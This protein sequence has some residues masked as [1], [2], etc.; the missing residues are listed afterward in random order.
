MSA[1][2][3]I[4]IVDE[5][6]DT[7]EEAA[8]IL[9]HGGHEVAEAA[10]VEDAIRTAHAN[11]PTLIL[12]AASA[13]GL[14]VLRRLRAAP[15]VADIPVVLLCPSDI[16]P[17]DHS[18]CVDLG[19][20]GYINRPV[21]EDELLARVG[22]HLRQ[23]EL[24]ARLRASEARFRDLVTNQADGVLV[25]GREGTIQFANPAA[26]ALFGRSPDALVGQPFGFPIEGAQADIIEIQ[27][28]GGEEIHAEMRVGATEWTGQ[29]AWIATLS[30]VT[31]RFRAEVERSGLLHE[32]GERI[33]ELRLYHGVSEI[34]KHDEAGL[35]QIVSEIV[36]LIPPA[37]QFPECAEAEIVLGGLH[38]ATSGYLESERSLSVGFP[39]CGAQSGH[40]NVAYPRDLPGRG[41]PAFLGEERSILRALGEM[42]R[43]TYDRRW[44]EKEN[45]RS[46]ALLRIAGRVARI[47]GWSID[48]PER[49]LT[50]SEEMIAIH[51]LPPGHQPTLEESVQHYLPGFRAKV[52]EMVEACIAHGTPI[53]IEAE[54]ISAKGRKVWISA[55]GE[56]VRDKTGR[57]VRLQGAMQDISA[58]KEAEAS[59]AESERRFR[60]LAE[61]MPMI[62]W[63]ADSKGNINFANQKLFETTGADPG[64]D[65]H[66]RWHSFVH[67]DDLDQALKEWARCVREETLYDI[68]YRL[69]H[70][71]DEQ[72]HWFRVQGQPI[73]DA[74]GAVSHWFGTGIDIHGIKTL[75]EK[76]TELTKRLT[77]TLESI[78]DGFFTLDRDWRFTYVNPEVERFLDADR[79][80]IIGKILWDEFPDVKGTPIDEAYRKAM[81]KNVTVRLETF[82]APAQRWINLRVYPSADGLS[83]FIQDI[84]QR[85]SDEEQMRLLATAMAS[86]NDIVIITKAAPLEEPGP[87]IVFVNDAFERL[88]GYTAAEALGRTPRMLQGPGSDLEAK[89][90]MRE[91]LAAGQTIREEVINYA[92]DGRPYLLEVN[93]H[94][95]R[96]ADGVVTHFVAVERDIT[97]EQEVKETL[98]ESEERFRTLL[99]DIP[100]VAIQ[101]YG[102]DGAVNYWNKASEALYG[103]T[104]EEAMQGNL[105][106]L[107]IPPEMRDEVRGALKAVEEGLDHLPSAELCLMRKDGSRVDVLSSHAVL[108]RPGH[109]VEFYCIDIDLTER[110][111]LETQFLRAQRMESIGTLAGGI[112]HDLN[113]MLSPVI[114]GASLMRQLDEGKTMHSIID[115]IQRSAER[116]RELVKQV[117]SFARGADGE[118]VILEVGHFVH[119]IESIVKSTFPKNITFESEIPDHLWKIPADPTQ[120]H[121]VLINLCVNARDAMPNGGLLRITAENLTVDRQY[122]SMFTEVRPGRY[123]VVDICDDGCGM[124]AAIRERVFEPFFTTKEFGDGTGLGLSTVM[125]IVRGH[126]G[127]INVYSEP[128]KGSRFRICLPSEENQSPV[129]EEKTGMAERTIPHGNGECILVVDDEAPI[130]T[131]SK[132]ALEAYGYKVI[133]AEDGAEGTGIFAIHQNEIDLLLTDIMMP[134]M[135]G[136]ALITAVKRINPELPV[137]ITSGL[138]TNENVAPVDETRV[139]RFLPKP[140]TAETLLNAVH[141]ALRSRFEPGG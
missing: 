58:R 42:L 61:S 62:V 94:P 106:E 104:E 107:I 49:T 30:D 109:P 22:L 100:T 116:G 2:A 127:F 15:E 32:L 119:E 57:I 93:L 9:R 14:D 121:Q 3:S 73:R 96:D 69:L 101:G 92:K 138:K 140:Y 131:M 37:M 7:R 105:L 34:L 40:I 124:D 134:I 126:D 36:R 77:R 5:A 66:T 71:Q 84:T 90:R 26:G 43:A 91:A 29:P 33:K 79:K 83:V 130:R 64:E 23:V 65:P 75:E 141:E 51:D 81:T 6:A 60:Q 132:L 53:E 125:G 135:D 86:I 10:N 52:A 136:P 38:D 48:L 67:P 128:G 50:W 117:L 28:P 35:G 63:T 112:A 115:S 123:I 27:R 47:G 118:R 113:N 103:Y 31:E 111:K 89:R 44:I 59:A 68:V 19:V 70:R 122:A 13:S 45:A 120:I 139:T 108:R 76:A 133:T 102:A 8:H 4:L 72:Y 17:T 97:G 24:T 1:A 80:E 98:R 18:E 54:I 85:R 21:A 56:A 129:N 11:P 110:K 82:Y 55:I 39:L 137:I 12:L 114:M 78:T 87:E 25:V 16:S 99:R 95:I 41:E 88:T 74:E 46:E 20:E